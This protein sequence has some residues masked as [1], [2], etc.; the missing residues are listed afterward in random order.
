MNIHIH[1]PIEVVGSP[2]V[3][4]SALFERNPGG[5]IGVFCHFA[6]SMIAR[7]WKLYIET[8]KGQPSILTLTLCPAD[9]SLYGLER[10]DNMVCSYNGVETKLLASKL[11]RSRSRAGHL[12][13][14]AVYHT[15]NA[16]RDVIQ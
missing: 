10:F 16:T 1:K 11:T 3:V 4:P 6:A 7:A 2:L 13:N 12:R 8:Y 15:P 9:Q 5:S 14:H